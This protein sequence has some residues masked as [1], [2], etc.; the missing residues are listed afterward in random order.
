MKSKIKEKR[1]SKKARGHFLKFR[2]TFLFF[3]VCI[4]VISFLGYFLCLKVFLQNRVLGTT[5]SINLLSNASFEEY[6][7]GKFTNWIFYTQGLGKGT[8]S[9]D[10]QNKIDGN[11]SAKIT[12]TTASSHSW[13]VQLSQLGHSLS[14]QTYAL[15]FWAKSDTTGNILAAIQ[16]SFSPFHVYF[17]QSVPLTTSWQKE[18][19]TFTMPSADTN[20]A[21]RFNFA[22]LLG[23]VWLD[24]VALVQIPIPT[25]TPSPMIII[26]CSSR[27][28][29][30]TSQFIYKAGNKLCLN[31]EAFKFAGVNISYLGFHGYGNPCF[32]PLSGSCLGKYTSQTIIDTALI[33]AAKMHETVIRSLSMVDSSGGI[34]SI[35]PS[36]NIFNDYA[37]SSADY[38]IYAAGKYHMHYILPLS[39]GGYYFDGG[40]HV[41]TDWLGLTN[42]GTRY[43][44][45]QISDIFTHNATATDDY[46]YFIFHVLNHVNPYTGLAYKNDPTIMAWEIGNEMNYQN[47]TPTSSTWSNPT[48][49]ENIAKYIKA[50]A[51]HQLVSDGNIFY[52]LGNASQN[53]LSLPDVDMYSDHFYPVNLTKLR[54][55][56]TDVSNAG[57]VYWVG[58]YDALQATGGPDLSTIINVL[59]TTPEIS[60]DIFFQLH[61]SDFSGGDKFTIQYPGQ[62]TK[63][64]QA[65]QLLTSHAIKINGSHAPQVI[66]PTQAYNSPKTDT[67]TNQDT[68]QS[69]DSA[70]Q[71]TP[72]TIGSTIT[73]TFDKI[74]GTSQKPTPIPT[75][76]SPQPTETQI[77]PGSDSFN[78]QQDINVSIHNPKPPNSSFSLFSIIVSPIL[79]L[80]NV[81]T[82][83]TKNSILH[84]FAR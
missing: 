24:N 67:Q 22:Q 33:D 25:P 6:A 11:S 13:D 46:K 58:E 51:P 45:A 39:D 38:A 16:Q 36:R 44:N 48:W 18:T 55:D 68:N 62:N 82:N 35:E 74:I 23:N 8:I 1:R 37:F 59:D 52:L 70:S 14:P 20:V 80:N 66:M 84:L 54:E 5:T 72:Q 42:P 2:S 49:E 77:I 19:L 53:I 26:S 10:T 31:G 65:I 57:K 27:N 29:S 76:L 56:A 61:G 21:V 75:T 63:T 4:L 79:K 71:S 7:S 15:T 40:E 32:I 47:S 50:I 30:T 43:T 17:Q 28:D 69:A 83:V 73:S 60:G 9:Q 78:T 41:F 3:F 81:I 12:V 34:T 64:Q